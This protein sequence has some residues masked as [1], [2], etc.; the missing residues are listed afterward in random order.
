LETGF[1]LRSKC[2]LSD[3]INSAAS[4]KLSN[5]IIDYFNKIISENQIARKHI[6]MKVQLIAEGR[7][8]ENFILDITKDKESGSFVKEGT[9]DDWNYW[10][11]IP[12]HLVQKAVNNE[13]LWETLF[14]SARWQGDRKPDQWNEHFIN[15]LYDPEPQR[16]ESIYKRYN[17]GDIYGN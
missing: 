5:E 3:K 2:F 16:I 4:P 13:L 6:D 11:K 7:N 12:A 14:L 9:T 1:G 15:L 8:G 10:M 17:M